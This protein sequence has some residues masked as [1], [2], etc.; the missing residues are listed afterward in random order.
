[1]RDRVQIEE[2]MW[3][4]VRALDGG[5]AEAYAAT[6][7]PDGQFGT[8][9]NA[10]KGTAALKKLVPDL[11]QRVAEDKAKGVIRSPMYHMSTDHSITFID[12]NH[13][14]WRPTTSR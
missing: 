9:A 14:R 11:A 8:G 3:R 4:Y 10:A 2:L 5:N 7:T 12:E 1:M 13:V 6:Y